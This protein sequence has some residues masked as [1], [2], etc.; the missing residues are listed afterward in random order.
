MA[1]RLNLDEFESGSIARGQGLD[2]LQVEWELGDRALTRFRWE[3]Y[4]R[5][6]LST[7]SLA[8]LLDPASPDLLIR[9][10]RG[11]RVPGGCVGGW[12]GWAVQDQLHNEF[13]WLLSVTS[14]QLAPHRGNFSLLLERNPLRLLGG[15][16]AASFAKRVDQRAIFL[17]TGLCGGPASD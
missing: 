6:V 12:V 7:R 9:L 16:V 3:R 8:E 4:L 15:Y 10:A 17:C 14:C 1:R 2:K 5:E 13:D 11:I